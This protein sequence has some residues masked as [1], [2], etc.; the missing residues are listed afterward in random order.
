MVVAHIACDVGS[1]TLAAVKG[2]YSREAVML[3]ASLASLVAA[4]IACWWRDGRDGL[5]HALRPARWLALLPVSGLFSLGT[6]C[7]LQAMARLPPLLVKILGQLKLPTTVLL[8]ALV[9]KRQYSFLQIQGLANIFFAVTAFMALQLDPSSES[10]N[11]DAGAVAGFLFVAGGII[12]NVFGSILAESEIK[13]G[14]DA[15]AF[16]A[17]VA[18][19]KVGECIASFALMSL[20]PKA[21][22]PVLEMLKD[23]LSMFDGFDAKAWCLVLL[24]IGDSWISTLVVQRLSSVVK[25]ISKCLSLVVLYLTSLIVFKTETFALPQFMLALLVASGAG[26]FA[27]ASVLAKKELRR[28]TSLQKRQSK[29]EQMRMEEIFQRYDASGKGIDFADF[30]NMC[31][32][33][34]ACIPEA[35]LAA[36]YREL[37]HNAD[38]RVSLEE[39][40]SFWSLTPGCGGHTNLVLNALRLRLGLIHC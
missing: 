11:L 4:A 5:L 28:S 19:L 17:T 36:A 40:S 25:S 27:Y 29:P 15:T 10:P 26:L 3:L 7:L 1:S 33:L 37:D 8:S 22:V 32:V 21:P 13:K 38:G 9:L 23:P 39:F 30:K 12:C 14:A 2:S 24:L 20:K 16:Y 18:N 6:W 31:E 34:G 35:S